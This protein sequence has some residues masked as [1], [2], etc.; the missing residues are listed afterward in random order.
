[1]Q[2]QEWELI[3]SIAD[4]ALG[5]AIAQG[6]RIDKLTMVM[7]IK[8]AHKDCPLDLRA[9]ASAPDAEFAHDVFGIRRHLNRETKKIEHCFM[10]RYAAQVSVQRIITSALSDVPKRKCANQHKGECELCK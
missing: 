4:R 6:I 10:P 5:M 7:D 1:V 2:K 8:F 3:S 9:L